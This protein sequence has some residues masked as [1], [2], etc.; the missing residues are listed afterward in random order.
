MYKFLFFLLVICLFGCNSKQTIKTK[1]FEGNALGTTYHIKFFSEE[2]VNWEKGLDSIYEVVN[3]SMSTY[4]PNSDISKINKGDTTIVVDNMFKE[5]FLLSKEINKSTSGYF[6]PTV[7][8]L[9][10]AYG[11]GAEELNYLSDKELDSLFV[12]VGI[13]KMELSEDNRLKKENINSYIE[14]NAVA[15]GYTIDRLAIFLENNNVDNYL[16]EL[17][18]ELRVKGINKEKK[19]AWRVGLDNPYQTELKREITAILELK[20]EALATSGNYRKFRQDSITGQRFVHTINPLT[21][22]AEKSN[23]LSA[24]VLATT[25][26]EADAYATAFMAMG[27]EKSK[28]VIEN[29]TG[30]DA[31]LIYTE[32]DSTK[33]YSTAKFKKQL[34]KD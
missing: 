17:G 27:L 7:G 21:G 16:I 25:C 30:I 23:I 11:F 31:Y 32:N 13:D 14:F 12:L 22:K 4:L 28:L 19:Q 20:N 9:V 5:V 3:K 33:V 15:K 2:E 1:Y 24:S 29:L 6:D 8:N 18:G 26:A 34:V 10:N